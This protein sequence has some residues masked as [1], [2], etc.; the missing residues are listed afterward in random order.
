MRDILYDGVSLDGDGTYYVRMDTFTNYI[1]LPPEYYTN[2]MKV[3]QA[4]H[5]EMVCQ[6]NSTGVAVCQAINMN[7]AQVLA[8]SNYTNITIRLTD[9]KAFVI[10]PSV[11]LQDDVT[12]NGIPMCQHMVMGSK[13]T[14]GI[15]YLGTTFLENYFVVYDFL[16]DQIGL[17]GFVIK[18][19]P[20]I[21]PKG[22]DEGTSAN[23]VLL[24]VILSII[25]VIL[26]GVVVA[27][28]LLY[29]KRRRL[30]KDLDLYNK[31]DTTMDA[32]QVY[33]TPT[34]KEPKYSLQ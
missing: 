9:D 3:M 1:K 13:Y 14:S 8:A 18:D 32:D 12:S 17:N 33:Q 23:S 15:I 21:P 4:N 31:L 22:D 26:L 20:V 10:P 6:D 30:R 2:F 11:Y 7:C 24:I 25:G 5:S 28:T 19:Q 16:N 27:V 34:I 29:V